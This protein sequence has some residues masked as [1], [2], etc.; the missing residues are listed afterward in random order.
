MKEQKSTENSSLDQSRS[1]G[2]IATLAGGIAHQF[3]N[4]LLG[5]AGNID[6]L[7][8]DLPEDKHIEK[9]LEPMKSSVRRMTQLTDQLLAYAR[10]GKY[11]P[12]N[13]SLINL[14][15]KT[16]PTLRR[17]LE[18]S[19]SVEAALHEN[20]PNVEADSA[21]MEMVLS[22]L[23]TNAAEAIKGSG[24]ITILTSK[25]GGGGNDAQFKPGPCACLEI[26]DSGQGMTEETRSRIFEPFFSTKFHGRGLGMAAVFGV[27]QN[28]QGWISVQS[29]PGQGTRVSIY[30]P[31]LEL[32]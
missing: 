22:A 7:S 5:I 26:R 8:V 18:P 14:V 6:L 21:Q 20:T 1:M 15:Q 25:H 27:V 17:K 16:L 29:S 28:H 31:A 3:N 2:A 24:H 32:Q 4:A 19:I 11:Q 23:V 9:Y 30:L 13:I 10:G 12:K